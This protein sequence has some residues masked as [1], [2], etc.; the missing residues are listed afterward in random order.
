MTFLVLFIN[1]TKSQKLQEIQ[2]E[3]ITDL[4][5]NGKRP[6]LR[7]DDEGNVY[8]PDEIVLENGRTEKIRKFIKELNLTNPGVAG[9]PTY[10]DE[11]LLTEEHRKLI[12]QGFDE[13]GCNTFISDMV[14]LNR[15]I[16]PIQSEYCQKKVYDNSKYPKVSIV[17][18]F[19]NDPWSGEL[20]WL[21]FGYFF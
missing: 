14:G 1:Y 15:V 2:S 13:Y 17:I 10:L 4:L 8:L 5:A 19:H 9:T 20:F 12:Q 7:I 18:A 21:D 11:K 6:D 3:K 16:P